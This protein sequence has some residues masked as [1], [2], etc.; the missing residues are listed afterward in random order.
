[1]IVYLFDNTGKKDGNSLPRTISTPYELLWL[2]LFSNQPD[3][4]V[5][6]QI[7]MKNT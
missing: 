1:M 4:Y 3:L 2:N 7:W 6:D 5:R